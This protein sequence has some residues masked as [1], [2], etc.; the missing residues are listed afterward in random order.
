MNNF[1]RG[2]D[3]SLTFKQMLWLIPIVLTLHNIEEALT[4]PTWVMANLPLIKENLPIAI[5]IHFTPTQLLLSLLLATVVPF[6]VTIV[7]VD[8]EKRSKKLYLLFLLQSVVLL[9]VFIPHIAASVRM[10]QYNPG[11]ITAVCLNL[12]FSLYVFRRSVPGTVSRTARIHIAVRRGAL[13]LRS[14]CVDSAF[15]GRVD[16]KSFVDFGHLIGR[17]RKCRN[18][19]YDKLARCPTSC[20]IPLTLRIKKSTLLRE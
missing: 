16:G 2:I 3:R 14:C 10:R 18:I 17:I 9:N 4:M 13:C 5:D 20:T 8:G 15:C 19:R 7:C 12:P 6:I 1:V 11:V